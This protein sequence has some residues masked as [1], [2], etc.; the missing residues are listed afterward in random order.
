MLYKS[1]AFF[2]S[3]FCAVAAQHVSINSELIIRP[4]NTC[5][6]EEV[7]HQQEGRSCTSNQKNQSKI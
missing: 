3:L 5:L 7:N 4:I 6:H 1:Y 2:L